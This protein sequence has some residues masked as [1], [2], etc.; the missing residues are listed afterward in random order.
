M[1]GH[2][3]HQQAFVIPRAFVILPN[4]GSQRFKIK[5]IVSGEIWLVEQGEKEEL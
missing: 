1:D 3:Y 4:E 5:A 2:V